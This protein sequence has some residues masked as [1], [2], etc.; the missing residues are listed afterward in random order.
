MSVSVP[1]AYTVRNACGKNKQPE[2]SGQKNRHGYRQNTFAAV[3]RRRTTLT[4][5]LMISLENQPVRVR[6]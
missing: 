1:G 3:D 2:I 6:L 5:K 4:A